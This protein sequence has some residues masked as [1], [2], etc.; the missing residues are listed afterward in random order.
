MPLPSSSARKQHFVHRRHRGI[1]LLTTTAL[2]PISAGA[3]FANPLGG[4][5]VGGN[6]TIQG[7]GTSTVTVTQSSDRAI[8][9]WKTFDLGA[10]DTTRF[11]QPSN[12][13]I[14]LDRVTG[15]LGASQIYGTV[16]ANGRV[17]LVN[18][19]GVLFGAGAKINTAGFLA[20]TNDI[21][22][23][24][25]MAGRYNFA[26]PGSPAASITNQG[27]ITAQSGGFAALVAP[28]VRNSGTITATLGTVALASGN[29]FTLDFY[30]DQLIKL[31]VGDSIATDVKDVATGLTLG[32]LVKN[33]GV[34]KA[35]GGQVTLAAVTARK[36]I[37]SVIN[38]TGVIEANSF[39]SHNGKIVLGAAT[40]ST[41]VAGAPTQAVKVSGSLS[42]AGKNAQQ[43][44]GTVIVTGENIVLSGATIDASGRAGGGKVLI[45]GDVG[46]GK[47]NST[48]A[49]MPQAALEAW[50]VPT[51][52][53][54]SVDAATTINASAIAQGDG[55]KVVVWSDQV[56][57]FA[58]LIKATGG[59]QSGNG[60][61]V[62]TSGH[63]VDFTGI[64]VDTSALA[65]K[66][67][68]WLVD[69]TD[70]TVGTAA[71]ATISTNLATTNVTL[72]TN[73]DG[74]T[75]GPGVTSAGLG[76]INVNAPISWSSGNTLALNANHAIHVN[77][78]ITI[79]GPG[80]LSLSAAIDPV[81][82]SVPM[83]F[84][85]LGNSVQFTGRPN[86]GQSL[87]INGQTYTLLYSMIDV[88]N[89]NAS[90]ASLSGNFAL[91]KSLDA[92]TVE[93]WT[94]IG[95]GGAGQVLNATGF[96]GAFEGLGNTI[97]NLKIGP[98]S[99][100][101]IGLFGISDGTI[102]NVGLVDET[103]AVSANVTPAGTFV[104]GLVG[105][106][107]GTIAQSFT[108][109]TVTGSTST[110]TP[111]GV[112]KFD[113]TMGGLVGVNF[114]TIARSVSGSSVVSPIVDASLIGLNEVD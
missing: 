96:T 92:S 33:E 68:T 107:A 1:L 24:D 71:A 111:K 35:N 41:K 76:D 61:L 9:N 84:F 19:D 29:T 57:S 4:Q 89:I 48:V 86:I 36:V 11:V 20:T 100:N 74:T 93:N 98:A 45:G 37:D 65:G 81:L 17:F 87:T 43:T 91:A 18:P 70:L 32:S 77:A 56:T 110:V 51:A 25:F 64:R 27:T 31:A 103:V 72:Q 80:G 104:G 7:Q 112:G 38:N 97:A 50:P 44:G 62:E 101:L 14:T 16:A 59:A 58:G 10:G 46:G 21:K 73:T 82:T 13:S 99:T 49:W 15:G 53:S 60:G 90:N 22:N 12:S 69:P 63:T 105:M 42:V 66:T 109:G 88:Q 6:A 5:V 8:I 67:G 114:G 102:H 30:G 54:V 39:Q 94:P 40:A 3:A 2:I 23:A 113:L 26:V 95:T 108:T 34:L 75:S 79:A 85:S 106:N 47:G 83:L 28:G 52:T 78:P 55:G